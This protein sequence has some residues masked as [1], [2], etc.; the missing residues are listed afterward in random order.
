MQKKV[1]NLSI[2]NRHMMLS[3]FV[4]LKEGTGQSL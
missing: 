1:L 4:R 3:A 2:R